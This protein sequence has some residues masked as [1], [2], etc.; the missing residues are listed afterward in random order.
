[1]DKGEAKERVVCSICQGA[2]GSSVVILNKVHW[3]A[4]PYCGGWG[5]YE[6]SPSLSINNI[7][8]ETTTL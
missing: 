6:K 8:N 4:C 3:K 2:R 1:M 5:Y 7:E